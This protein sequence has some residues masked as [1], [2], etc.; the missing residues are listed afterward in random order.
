MKLI[1]PL[2]KTRGPMY[3][4][5][6]IQEHIYIHTKIYKEKLDETRDGSVHLV[7]H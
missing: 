6:T 1:P 5:I 4:H 7:T 3:I 2:L